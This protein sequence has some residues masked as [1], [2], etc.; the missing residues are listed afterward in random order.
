LGGAFIGLASLQFGSVVVLGKIVTDHGLPVPS[1]L[2]LRFLIAAALLSVALSVVRQPLL[3]APGERIPLA[4]LGVAGYAVE[5]GLFFAAVRHGSAA[6]VTLLFFTYP[7]W[8]A[9]VAFATGKGL[10]GWLLGGALLAAVGGAALVVLSS[11][12][13]DIT[14]AGILFA[15]G[16]AFSFALYLTIV[17]VVLKRTNALTG[18]MWVSAAAGSALAVFAPLSGSA[19]LPQGAAQ[20]AS[21]IGTAAFTAGAFVCLFAGL[22]RLG[23]VRTSIVAATEPLAATTLAVIFLHEQLRA[24]TVG[25]GMLILAGAVAASLARRQPTGEPPVP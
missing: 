21:V 23:P 24:G 11:G 9:L 16:S 17:D 19:G 13:L 25:G 8:V 14:T 2:A 6:A 15:F 18:S 20:W 12:G 10:P 5:A 1:F 22:R 7:V 4:L 3:A